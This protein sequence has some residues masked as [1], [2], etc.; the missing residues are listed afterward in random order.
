M[1]RF[2]KDR[3]LCASMG[4]SGRKRVIDHFSRTAFAEKLEAVCSDLARRP[5]VR[6]S[7]ALAL[8]L[9]FIVVYVVL[10]VCVFVFAVQQ[11]R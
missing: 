4:R 2:V 6:N 10:P 9:A 3:S 11:F 1:A 8:F 5:R 7:K